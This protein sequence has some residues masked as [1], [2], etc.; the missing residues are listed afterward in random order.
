MF[1]EHPV[2]H[3]PA[4]PGI[5]IWRYID[6]PKYISLLND[7]A[8]YFCRMDKLIDQFEG[9]LPKPNIILRKAHPFSK[10]FGQASDGRIET[11]EK[12]W[13]RMFRI[14]RT[15]SFVNCWHMNNHESAAMWQLYCSNTQGMAIRS[16]YQALCH[17]LMN[18]LLPVYIGVVNYIDY[19][20]EL[21][22]EPGSNSP[23]HINML[24]PLMHKRRSY[25]HEAELR[26]LVIW[27]P[28]LKGK[29]L[30]PLWRKPQHTGTLIPVDLDLLIESVFVAPNAEPWFY[31]VVHSISAKYGLSIQPRQSR[32]GEDPLF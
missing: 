26:A 19:D 16:T 4:D 1:K 30:K 28:P 17:S 18:Y 31:K 8:L 9:S 12:T 11:V 27:D 29:S 5:Y 10:T 2:C 24:Y 6:L 25:H 22:Q 15:H 14:S 32:L 13:A 3:A 7:K 23:M 20:N 21:I